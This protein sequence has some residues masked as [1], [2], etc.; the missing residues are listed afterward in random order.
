MRIST[1]LALAIVA[2][3]LIAL[4][5]L[6]DRGSIAGLPADDFAR[7]AALAAMAL[8]VGGG[9]LSRGRLGE[10]LKAAAIWLVVALGLVT[11]YAYRPELE[12]AG[13]RVLAVLKPGTPIASQ[14]AEGA[15]VTVVRGQDGHFSLTA[16]V[17]GTSVDFLVDTGASLLTLT[18]RDAARIGIEPSRLVFSTPI[19][20][21]NGRAFAAP[22]RIAELAIGPIVES[23]VAALVADDRALDRSLLGM[24]VLDG[25]ASFAFSGD[26][27]T[28]RK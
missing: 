13:M 2:V 5:A 26:R 14:T 15:V 16:S 17:E 24:N 21:A 6:G 27:L 10:N 25:L 1:F 3:A 4:I 18:A 8:F 7:A 22:I 19:E 20:T 11:G 23:N 28:L 12:A 9:V